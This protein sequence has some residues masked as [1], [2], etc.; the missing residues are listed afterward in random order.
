[1]PRPLGRTSS[2]LLLTGSWI[3]LWC[4]WCE[5]SGSSLGLKTPCLGRNWGE[6]EGRRP[7]PAILVYK[8]ADCLPKWKA[9]SC[10]PTA[11]ILG[12]QPKSSVVYLDQV[13]MPPLLGGHLEAMPLRHP[14]PAVFAGRC[15]STLPDLE[16]P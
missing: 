5:P 16:R 11:Q 10:S 12:A 4:H 2:G 7:L 14:G 6:C 15:L 8:T 3:L 1:M 9:R 13:Q